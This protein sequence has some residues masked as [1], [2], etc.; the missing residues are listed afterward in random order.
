VCSIPTCKSRVKKSVTHIVNIINWQVYHILYWQKRKQIFSYT[1]TFMHIYVITTNVWM[2]YC[3]WFECH[4][5]ITR[6]LTRLFET[7]QGWFR[8][9]HYKK[10]KS[11]LCACFSTSF[12]NI[13]GGI[14]CIIHFKTVLYQ[15]QHLLIPTGVY[16]QI[17]KCECV[18]RS[19]YKKLIH[20]AYWILFEV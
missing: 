10:K 20:T 11:S 2:T 3:Q 9:E 16:C 5:Q 4:W 17:R 15:I 13:P 12:P 8:N 18:N 14:V 7:K 6:Q 1:A 19:F